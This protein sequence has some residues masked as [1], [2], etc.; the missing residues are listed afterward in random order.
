MISSENVSISCSFYL[1]IRREV[2]VVC[3][4]C[5]LLLH[6]LL[7]L[8]L[9]LMVSPPFFSRKQTMV[10]LEGA[11]NKDLF[12]FCSY[13]SQMYELTIRS[14]ASPSPQTKLIQK[15]FNVTVNKL[16]DFFMNVVHWCDSGLN[17]YLF[18]CSLSLRRFLKTEH[19]FRYLLI[20]CENT[21][22]Q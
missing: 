18:H 22:K 11:L 14:S 12:A 10:Q 19:V 2:K 1:F 16:L 17:T 3:E 9:F 20:I 13:H 21:L 5:F 6:T 8:S 4:L 15:L 7:F